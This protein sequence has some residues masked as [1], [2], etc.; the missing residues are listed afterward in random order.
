MRVPERY[1]PWIDQDLRKLMQTRDRL[2]MAAGKKK[3]PLLMDAY[4]QVR[5]EINVFNLQLKKQYYT[6]KIPACQG[7]MKES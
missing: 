7:N 6:D 5:N 4:S 2:K 1:H 3:S